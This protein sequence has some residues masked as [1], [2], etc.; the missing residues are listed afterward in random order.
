MADPAVNET[1]IGSDT[2]IKGDMTVESRARI[3]GK[4]EGTIRAKG[5][6][7]IAD[8]AQCRADVETGTVQIDGTMQGNITASDKAQLNATARVSGDLVAAKLIVAEG[9]AFTGHVSVGPDAVKG[10]GHHT[11]TPPAPPAPDASDKSGKK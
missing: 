2:T 4:F 11:P 8:A 3:L 7:E 10:S 1:V 5:H 6:L 9:A